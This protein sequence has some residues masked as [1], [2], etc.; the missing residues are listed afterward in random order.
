MQTN[1]KMCILSKLLHQFQILHS[2]KDHQMLFVGGLN[3]SKTNPRRQTAG[4]LIKKS[5]NGH[6]ATIVWLICIK[7]ST[8]MH[9][10]PPNHADI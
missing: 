4:I 6:I 3:S 2:Y 5:K 10:G 1:I 8:V 9:I 7:F